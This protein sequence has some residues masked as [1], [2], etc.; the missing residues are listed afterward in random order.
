LKVPASFVGGKFTFENGILK[1]EFSLSVVTSEVDYDLIV[2]QTVINS[3][4]SGGSVAIT[5]KKTDSTGTTIY[6]KNNSSNI[7]E[8]KLFQ[9]ET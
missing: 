9:G 5:M 6:D 7:K 2:S 8:F 1:K 3:T 4:S